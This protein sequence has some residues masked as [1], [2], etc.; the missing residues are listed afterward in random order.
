MT[1]REDTAVIGM[2]CRLPDAPTI[3]RF[4]ANLVSGQDSISH[5][6]RAELADAGVP[7]ELLDDPAYVPARGYVDGADQF[8]PG[9]FGYSPRDAALID[10][11][12]RLLLEC[13]VEA[14]ESAGWGAS[15]GNESGCTSAPA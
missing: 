11:Q 6:T 9:Y 8:D 13:A 10:A 14:L 12:Q 2:S 7:A 15:P 1:S 5:F 4:W 3:E